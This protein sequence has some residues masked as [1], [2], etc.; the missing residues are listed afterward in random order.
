MNK[1]SRKE[2]DM[3]GIAQELLA[4]ISKINSK[5]ACVVGLYGDLGAGK[6]TLTKAVGKI[7]GIKRKLSSPTF[8][9]IKRYKINN[10][11]HKNLFHL[12]AY[13]LKNEKELINL[14]WEAIISNPENLIFIE[15]PENVVKAMPKS[16]HKVH[17]K[18]TKTG[19]RNLKVTLSK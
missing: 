3:T 16:H 19:Y 14:G 10:K 1:I 11:K 18:H 8:V 2:E 15:W 6:T 13:R 9:I 12:D 17:I 5:M 4:N 7:L